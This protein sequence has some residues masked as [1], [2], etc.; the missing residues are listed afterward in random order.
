MNKNVRQKIGLRIRMVRKRQKL[1]QENLAEKAGLTGK[2]IGAI[3]R[4]ESYPSFA[5]LESIATA[6]EC[7]LRHFFE[8]DYIEESKQE[9]NKLIQKRIKALSQDDRRYILKIMDWLATR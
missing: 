3:E 8:I 6:L 4:G 9:L 2:F 1:T 5:K 7:D